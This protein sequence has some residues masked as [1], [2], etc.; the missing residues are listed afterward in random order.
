MSDQALRT[1]FAARATAALE[2]AHLQEALTIATN[3][4]MALR[5]ESFAG[6]PEGE[7]L[8]DRARAVKEATLQRLDA[9][10]EQLADSVERLGGHVHWAATG[11]EAREII[12]RLC[13]ERGVRT[14]VK[15]KS[16][17]TEEIELNA[18]LEAAGVTPVETDLGEYI[19][20]LAGE[21]PSHIIAPAIHKTKG[22]VADLFSRELGERFPADPEVLTAAARKELR[23]KFLQADLGITG[24]NFAVAE[25]G[26]V[27][28]VTNEGNGR[29][30]TSLPR[31][32]VAVMGIEK[33]I[34]SMTD[35]MLFLAILARSATGQKLS[36]YT[37]LV[38]GPR[39][40]GELEGPEEFHLILMDSGRAA[41]IAGPL[42]EALYCLRC[43][44]C[45]NVCPVYRQIGGHAYGH[46]YPGPI[47]ILLTAMLKGDRSVKELAHASSL[48]G[49]CHEVCP[50]RIDIP[51]MLVGLRERLYRDRIAPWGE[52]LVFWALG[53]VLGSPAL[54]RLL[55]RLGRL[56][57]RP[58]LRDG[59]VRSLP[60]L[61]GRW[62][63]S[64]D[65]PPVAARTFSECWK[66]LGR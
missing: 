32:H 64:R 30:V 56:A 31:I 13:R 17:A 55:V 26:T 46:T 60:F 16:M 47:G 63:R 19:I 34:P 41:Q 29:M 35:L 61:F 10:L 51:R 24:A 50:V 3:K 27:V 18:A 28:L 15:S 53:R 48:C 23:Q 58:F 1:P 12:L 49:A 11:E 43:G 44:A 39:H 33:V 2:D 5:R 59:R 6:F 4:F 65:L 42:R 21:K 40:P 7:A 9:Y 57:Q 66:E 62:T 25:T 54:F 14:A 22:Q 8:R 37:T 52:R 20:Q 45:L 36:V 38:R